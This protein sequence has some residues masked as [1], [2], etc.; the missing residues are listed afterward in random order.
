MT[1]ILSN[2]WFCNECFKTISIKYLVLILMLITL[3]ISC[4]EKNKDSSFNS[5]KESISLVLK[6]FPMIDSNLTAVR[7][8]DLDSLS[9]TLLRNNNKTVYDEVLVFEK[10][11]KFYSIPFF[12]NMYSDYWN[13]ENDKQ[14]KLFP[15]T[16]STFEKEFLKLIKTLKINPIE[17]D[18]ILDE[19][20]FTTL[21]AENNIIDKSAILKNKV[22]NT[23]RV[24]RY[25]MEVSDSCS[26]RTIK[27]FDQITKESNVVMRRF[28]YFFDEK[29][30]RIYRFENESKNI[31][32]LKIRIKTYRVDCYL[33]HF[34][35]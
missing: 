12:S 2:K 10:K 14:P 15:K 16:N 31:N 17:F 25:S 9:I 11:D 22:Y 28:E 33:Y 29:N 23:S 18:I 26:K 5:E 27:I 32:E 24:D 6:K 35:L 1:N 13:F 7:K 20:M 8:I 30:G 21:H 19:L 4:K 34:S 3:L